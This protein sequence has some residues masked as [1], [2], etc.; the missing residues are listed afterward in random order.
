MTTAT[1][2]R[3]ISG[4]AGTTCTECGSPA[5]MNERECPWCCEP[6]CRKCWI[7]RYAGQCSACEKAHGSAHPGTAA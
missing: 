2:R 3:F 7:E 4:G 6:M 5:I 1:M